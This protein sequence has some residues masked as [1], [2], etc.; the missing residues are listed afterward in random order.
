MLS[1]HED[2]GTNHP[3]LVDKRLENEPDRRRRR[4]RV[5]YVYAVWSYVQRNGFPPVTLCRR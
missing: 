5:L 4:R 1:G 2:V 3:G